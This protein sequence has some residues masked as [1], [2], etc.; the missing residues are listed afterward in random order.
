MWMTGSIAGKSD[1]QLA[2]VKQALSQRFEVKILESCT[3]SGFKSHSKSRINIGMK[4]AN[5]VDMP[6]DT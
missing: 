3:L 6:V 2:E 5:A 4:N 1:A